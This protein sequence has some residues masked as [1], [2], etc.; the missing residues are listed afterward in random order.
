MSVRIEGLERRERG[1]A[2]GENIELVWIDPV[3]YVPQLRDAVRMLHQRDLRVS[4]YN[5]P[6]CVLPKE[7][8]RFARDSISDWKKRYLAECQ[9]CDVR[10]DCPGLFPT[11]MRQSCGIA[12]VQDARVPRRTG[13]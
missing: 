10:T 6:L 1:Q 4:V 7:L 9:R 2:D 5:L 13:M 8:W 12:P 11:S 3:E